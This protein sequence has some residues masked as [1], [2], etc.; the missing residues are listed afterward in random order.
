VDEVL[1]ALLKAKL[2]LPITL[3]RKVGLKKNL[4]FYKGQKILYK[5]VLLVLVCLIFPKKP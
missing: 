3:A 1:V 5:L 4:K 2:Y